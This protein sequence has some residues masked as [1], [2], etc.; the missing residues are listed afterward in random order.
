MPCHV[1]YVLKKE[2]K[3]Y[4]DY[5]IIC[6]LSAMVAHS[7]KTVQIKWIERIN[8]CIVF[9]LFFILVEFLFKEIEGIIDVII[10]VIS[11]IS[12]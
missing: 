1:Q 7:N 4:L 3:L 10:I 2:K 5:F 12:F 8:Q 6:R 9:F 11:F